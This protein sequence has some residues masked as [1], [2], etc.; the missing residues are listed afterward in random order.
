M[1]PAGLCKADKRV[2]DGKTLTVKLV[3]PAGVA[4]SRSEGAIIQNMLAQINVQVEIDTVPS[5]DFF[6]KYVTPGR[7]DF[8]LFSWIGTPFPI[9]S[10]QSIYRSRQG[11]TSGRTTRGS[12]PMKSTGSI[13]RQLRNSIP[14]RR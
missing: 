3:I 8:T 7:F 6:D 2:K 1:K 11:T 4:V 13:M 14:L 10:V 9:S 5:D 12:A